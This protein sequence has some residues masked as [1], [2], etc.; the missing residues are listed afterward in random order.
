[1]MNFEKACGLAV[2]I[3][4]GVFGCQD[5]EVGINIQHLRP[6]DLDTCL[7]SDDD[8]VFVVSGIV[9]LA[10]RDN[11]VV[12]PSIRNNLFNVGDIKG[13]GTQD[14]RISTNTIVLE[15]AEIT[16]AP[17]D[18]I[19]GN[20]PKTRTV[21]LSGTIAEGTT[22]VLSYFPLIEVEVMEALRSSDTF[23]LIDDRGDARPRRTSITILTTFRV[24][25]STLDGRRVSSEEF[26]FPVEV[27]NGCMVQYPSGILE[28]RNGGLFCPAQLPM[29]VE[30]TTEETCGQL[31]GV[32]GVSV[33][34]ID[35][36]G[37]AVNSFAR[38]LCQPASVP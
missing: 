3:L 35:C 1:M 36:Q 24:V 23:F 25:G 33:N 14:G 38:Q 2:L 29:T 7:P 17:L 5:Q 9:D 19:V 6:F 21:P 18:N 10:L 8:E 13:L 11:Y 32:D 31:I 28:E 20:I 12:N 4:M 37:M 34:C 16:Y 30:E 26:V 15:Q 22:S 27:C